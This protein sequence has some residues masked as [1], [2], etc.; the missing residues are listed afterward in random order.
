MKKRIAVIFGGEG[1]EHDVS[2]ASAAEVI[3]NL[4]SSLFEPVPVGISRGGDWYIYGGD[5]INI[6]SARW[7][8]DGAALTSV[9]PVRRGGLSGLITPRGTIKIDAAL[10]VLHGDLGEDGTVQGALRCAGIPTAGCG[11]LG[12]ALC[13]DKITV[14]RVADAMGIPTLPWFSVMG[15]E[16]RSDAVLHAA[17]S[18]GYPL[19]V[20]PSGLGSSVGIATVRGACELLAALPAARRA[21]RLGRVLIEKYIDGARELECAVLEDGDVRRILPPG[22]VICRGVYTYSEKY[23]EDSHTGTVLHADIPPDTARR[24]RDMTDALFSALAIRD[25]CRADYLLSPDGDIYLNEINTFP[26]MTEKSLYPG[27]CR[28]GG[29]SFTAML[30]ILINSALR[31]GNA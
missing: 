12:G 29:I 3:K 27:M 8:G 17:D 13:C 7:A 2:C 9:F 6:A 26:G 19:I 5:P 24:I 16:R 21:D 30:T 31:R 11:V 20:K 14:K 18:I 1:C 15:D 10:P 28:D 23:G 25:L 4:D 22:E